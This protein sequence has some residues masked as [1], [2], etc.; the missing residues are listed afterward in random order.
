M[1]TKKIIILGGSGAIGSA[2]AKQLKEKEYEPILI[3]RNE[4]D[5]EV[6]S[7]K[8]NC[9]YYVCNI[10]DT[11]K[12]NDTIQEIGDNIF[13]LAYCVGSINLRSLRL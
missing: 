3:S 6:I 11:K 1:S 8:L 12:L 9:Q 4:G 10:L 7:K 5:L 13:G 2:I